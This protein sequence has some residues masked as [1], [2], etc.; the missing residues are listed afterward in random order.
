MHRASNQG[1][2]LERALAGVPK[3]TLGPPAGSPSIGV[4]L[5]Q[6]HGE[7]WGQELVLRSSPPGLC[8][9]GTEAPVWESRAEDIHGGRAA[10][11][12]IS[13]SL[14]TVLSLGS[15]E[16]L[17]GGWAHFGCSPFCLTLHTL[18]PHAALE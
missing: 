1:A 14:G 7:P 12:V 9:T 3:H 17:L 2:G 4:S 13:G 10:G 8:V 18:S 6:P 11:Q 5:P 15:L 16:T